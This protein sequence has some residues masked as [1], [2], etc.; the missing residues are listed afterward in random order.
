VELSELFH[1]VSSELRREEKLVAAGRLA[2]V[3]SAGRLGPAP[4]GEQGAQLRA[5]RTVAA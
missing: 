5:V 1:E 3:P 2:A 4:A